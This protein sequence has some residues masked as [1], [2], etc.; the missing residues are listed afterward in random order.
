MLLAECAAAGVVIQLNTRIDDIERI[1]DGFHV[2]TGHGTSKLRVISSRYRRVVYPE[3]GRYA[4]LGYQ[5]SRNSFGIP[6]IP[7]RAGL[8]PFTLQPEDKDQFLAAFG[9]RRY[10][11]PISNS[12]AAVLV[13][14]LLFT[15][16]GLSGPAV[17]QISSYWRIGEAVVINLLPQL[18]LETELKTKRREKVKKRLKNRAG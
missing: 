7:T 12:R 3:N 2:K 5:N 13:K 18:N 16:R 6:V 4:R 8:A 1:T 11:V 9:H 14:R 15:H 17:L 10:P